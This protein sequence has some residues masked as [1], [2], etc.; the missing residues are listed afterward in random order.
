[1]EG[2]FY[3]TNLSNHP[4]RKITERWVWSQSGTLVQTFVLYCT[5]L[6]SLRDRRAFILLY[7]NMEAWRIK[8]IQRELKMLR[9]VSQEV[10]FIQ[11]DIQRLAV[12]L[13]EEKTHLGTDWL[14]LSI[15]TLF[16]LWGRWYSKI[17]IENQHHTGRSKLGLQLS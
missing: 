8:I 14:S 12:V 16:I 2:Y 4:V 6:F 15:L 1:M 10:D 3:N 9:S 13:R 7:R 11:A 17:S 5:V